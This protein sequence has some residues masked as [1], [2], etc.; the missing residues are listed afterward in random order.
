MRKVTQHEHEP[1]FRLN[2]GEYFRIVWRKKYFIIVPVAISVIV[3]NIG[4]RFLV[5]E[6]EAS[7]VIRVGNVSS[8]NS[9]VDRY[10]QSDLRRRSHDAD[11]GAQMEADILG[12]AFLDDLIH[13]LGMNEDPMLVSEAEY[14]RETQ[15]PGVSTEELVMRRLRGFLRKNL[16]VKRDGPSLFRISYADANPEACYVIA[17]AVARLYIEEQKK[18]TAQGYHEVSEFSEEQLAVYKERLD[19]S[20]RELASFQERMAN[21]SMSGSLVNQGNIAAAERARSDLKLT[22][23]SAESILDKIRSRVVASAGGV[24]SGNPVW[25]DAEMKK[26]VSDLGNQ[27]ESQLI[28]SPGTAGSGT[29]PATDDRDDVSA[30][31]QKIQRRLQ[32]IVAEQFPQVAPDYRPLVVEYFYQQAEIDSY[33]R[34]LQ[35][36]DSSIRAFRQQLARTPQMETELARLRQDVESNRAVYNT[37][38]SAK[39]TNQISEAAQNSSLGENVFIVEKATRPLAPVRPN[40][41]KILALA[42]FMGI[43][44]GGAGLLLTEFS[45]SSFRTV[46]EVERQLGIKV[47]GT[48]PRFERSRWR[49]DTTRKRTI[50]WSAT[51][52]VTLAVVISAFY[53]YG[54]SSREAM[55]EL[56]ISTTDTGGAKP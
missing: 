23:D 52:V 16:S 22:I 34:K 56:N 1:G 46:D 54:R 42:L 35:R 17:D 50:I 5:P 37:F 15:Y 6:Y 4:V 36:L 18:Q 53:F 41:V 55:I 19:R 44:I 31:E 30:T 47:L 10:V 20:E 25:N 45:D 2:L 13:R 7:T 29:P 9:E 43:A 26:L 8:V 38:K 51:V 14:Q 3:S 12:S 24:P 39:E 32:T 40:K 27:R 11:V 48:V 28:T 49:H 21:E 33:R